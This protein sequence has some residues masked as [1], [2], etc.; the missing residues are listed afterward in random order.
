[1]S[2]FEFENEDFFNIDELVQQ[3]EDAQR[4]NKSRFFDQEDFESIIEYYQFS[5]RYDEAMQVSD[6]S[7]K[8]H[9]SSSI[10]WIKRAQLYF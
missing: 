4:K 8:Q 5:G 3:Y 1:M 10:L 2:D 7:L 6:E 9:A